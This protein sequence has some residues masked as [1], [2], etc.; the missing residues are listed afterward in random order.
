M[1]DAP[2]HHD[3]YGIAVVDE[4]KC[5]GCRLCE[6]ACGWNA[7]YIDPPRELLKKDVYPMEIL[8]PKRGKGLQRTRA[9]A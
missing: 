7:I 9:G 6:E 8:T 1:Q 3:F 5:V 4:K 2:N